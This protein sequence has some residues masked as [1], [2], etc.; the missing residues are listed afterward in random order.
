MRIALR[1]TGSSW[2]S[3]ARW[4]PY[5]QK[6]EAAPDDLRPSNALMQLAFPTLHGILLGD[7]PGTREPPRTPVRSEGK[8][9]ESGPSCARHRMRVDL[10]YFAGFHA[11]VECQCQV[12]RY[13]DRLQ[14]RNES[15]H[16][17]EAVVRWRKLRTLPETIEERLLRESAQAPALQTLSLRS[18]DRRQSVRRC[19]V[20]QSFLPSGCSLVSP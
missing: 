4:R 7:A 15:S 12:K 18:Q 19:C 10:G 20:R 8:T 13:L 11:V 3:G 16:R 5:P 6:Q 14:T 9:C 2:A 1:L 17:H